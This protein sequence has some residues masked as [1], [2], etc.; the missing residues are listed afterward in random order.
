MKQNLPTLILALVFFAPSLIG[1]ISNRLDPSL[2]SGLTVAYLAAGGVVLGVVAT[3]LAVLL[4]FQWGALKPS[5]LI[6]G[7][8]FVLSIVIFVLANAGML[9]VVQ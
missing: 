5:Y 1:V 2:E 7:I 3:A 6:V 9:S 8:C 4:S